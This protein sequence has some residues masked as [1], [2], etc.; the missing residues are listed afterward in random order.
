MTHQVTGNQQKALANAVYA[1]AAHIENLSAI[2]TALERIE[3]KHRALQVVP[4][5]YPIVG[6]NLLGAIKEVLGDA[7]TEDI[8]NAWGEAYGIIADIFIRME[9]EMY[10]TSASIPGGWQGWREFIVDRK[11]KESDVI[12]SF[13]LKPKD[14]KL[15]ADY[16][17]GQYLTFKMDIP[18]AE[19]TYMRHYSISDCAGKGYYRIS[20]KREDAKDE[21]PAG[22]ISNYLHQKISVGGSL[23]IS[24]PAGDF[25]LA[26]SNSSEPVIL[27]AGGIGITPLM[28]ILNSIIKNTPKRQVVFIQAT[29]NSK[30]QA[31][32]EYLQSVVNE[33]SNVTWFKVYSQPT[34][35]DRRMKHYDK[36]GRIDSEWL[37]TILKNN[38]GDYYFCGVPDFMR[39]LNR[40]LTGLGVPNEKIHY[41]FFE[42]FQPL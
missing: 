39:A 27:I 20:V 22:I 9:N 34:E 30:T 23:F 13:Y 29:Q 11:E 38:E 32:R 28:A 24:V 36:E 25:Y 42:S 12:T 16:F 31:F 4:E 26:N 1:A 3:H 35:E 40:A 18:G 19:Y 14:Q 10:I 41:E 21:I 8:L 17:P 7:A 2:V 33:H 6:T 15:I 5:Q 37:K